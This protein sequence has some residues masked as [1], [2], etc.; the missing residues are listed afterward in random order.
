MI[1]LVSAPL[2]YEVVKEITKSNLEPVMIYPNKLQFSLGGGQVETHES[3]Q[4]PI[5]DI[6][7]IYSETSKAPPGYY[8]LQRTASGMLAANM[9]SGNAGKQ[10]YICYA[11]EDNKPPIT[12]VALIFP[13]V[14]K[15][16]PPTFEAILE[17]PSAEPASLNTGNKGSEA[18]LCIS[19]APGTPITGLTICNE[20]EDYILPED[21]KI[22][23]LSPSGE[24]AN[25][26]RAAGGDELLLS[27]KGGCDSYFGF[28]KGMSLFS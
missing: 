6:V 11:R 18:F 24:R 27:Y 7:V 5:T 17:T 10:M 8:L 19:K 20:S 16:P 3:M 4:K 15:K 28:N 12:G 25:L 2:V 23:E 26:N 13:D 1:D 14:D 22:L 9:N 21:F